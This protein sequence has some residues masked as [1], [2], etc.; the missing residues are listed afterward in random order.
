MKSLIIALLCSFIPALAWAQDIIIQDPYMRVA[1]KSA[2]AGAIFMVIE[3]R[4]ENDDRLIAAHT[5]VAKR[6]EL[7]THIEDGDGVMK[8]RPV[9]E[10]FIVPSGVERTLKRGGDHVMV[11]GFETTP[12]EGESVSLILTFAKA[13]DIVIEVAVRALHDHNHDMG[14]GSDHSTH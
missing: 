7:H 2:K 10:G 4:A 1:T 13:G 8:M 3:N 14:H 11:M 12:Q 6:T 5:P 9:H